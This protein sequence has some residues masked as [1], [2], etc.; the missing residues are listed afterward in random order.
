VISLVV[1]SSQSPSAVLKDLCARNCAIIQGKYSNRTL[2][3]L[4]QRSNKRVVRLDLGRQQAVTEYRRED[5]VMSVQAGITFGALSRLLATNKQYFPCYGPTSRTL[6]DAINLGDAGYLEHGYGGMRQLVLGLEIALPDGRQIKT[7]GRVVKNVTG[8]DLTK[9]FLGARG[10]LGLPVLAHI[11][12]YAKPEQAA[13]LIFIG[14]HFDSLL[15]SAA[16]LIQTGLPVAGLELLFSRDVLP[17]F[18]P[19]G[20]V[21]IPVGAAERHS[22][23]L[24]VYISEYASVLSELKPQ[25]E[26]LCAPA[27]TKISQM[28]DDNAGKVFESIEGRCADFECVETSV[29][30][31]TARA[32]VS[33]IFNSGLY[34]N[35]HYRP[36]PGRLRLLSKDQTMLHQAIAIV[37]QYA[38][39]VEPL[40]VAYPDHEYDYHLRRLPAEDAN[41][42]RIKAELKESFDPT[43]CM[44]PFAI[45]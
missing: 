3:R 42:Q 21:D 8:Y 10:T 40:V 44:N 38:S 24:F 30:L 7:G 19:P 31:Q 15:D 2:E 29:P 36:G 16:A 28:I 9:L 32:I 39:A 43:G 20:A 4:T 18:L 14:D 12:L 34:I 45:V 27:A 17:T 11:R 41:L 33:Y 1:D 37:A 22:C 23:A 13:T 35:A 26:S 25:I 5:Q 6:L